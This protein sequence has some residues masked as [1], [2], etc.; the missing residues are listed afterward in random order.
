MSPMICTSKQQQM[1]PDRFYS[2][3]WEFKHASG[4]FIAVMK[5]R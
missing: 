4:L 5:E 1:I 2:T 3:G